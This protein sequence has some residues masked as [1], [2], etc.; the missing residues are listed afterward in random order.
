MRRDR[1]RLLDILDAIEN[2]ERYLVR[3]QA[4]YDD[5]E[6]IQTWMIRHLEII[7][8]ASDCLSQET[9]ELATSV[10]WRNIKGLRNRIAH[11]Y[12]RVDLQIVWD[13]VSRDIPALKPQIAELLKQV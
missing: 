7:G 13:V 3:G 6:L 2:I 12:F 5:D 1:D 11:E 9:Q 4:A 8:E 10:D